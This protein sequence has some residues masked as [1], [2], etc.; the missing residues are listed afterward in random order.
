MLYWYK[1]TN[2]DVEGAAERVAGS[3]QQR[4]AAVPA[5]TRPL[6]HWYKSTNTDAGA[7]RAGSAGEGLAGASAGEGLAGRGS[8]VALADIHDIDKNLLFRVLVL[9]PFV[10]A[11]IQVCVCVC[12][13]V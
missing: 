11:I 12:V 4:L 3:A 2:T 10:I 6:L 9:G 1:G 7:A 8:R 13:C 5:V